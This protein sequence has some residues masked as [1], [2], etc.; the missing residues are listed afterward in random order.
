ML[1]IPKRYTEFRALN[2]SESDT[3][4][5]YS[6]T[7]YLMKIMSNNFFSRLHRR[8]TAT[9][10]RNGFVLSIDVTW[11]KVHQCDYILTTV[12]KRWSLEVDQFETKMQKN[13]RQFKNVQYSSGHDAITLWLLVTSN[14]LQIWQID[15]KINNLPTVI[16]KNW[17]IY[18][19]LFLFCFFFSLYFISSESTCLK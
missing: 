9:F 11:K 4:N 5:A 3:S 10:Y 12:I 8:Q 7:E 19:V 2:I 18:K 14:L 17:K 15:S 6:A 16:E 1:I 13:V